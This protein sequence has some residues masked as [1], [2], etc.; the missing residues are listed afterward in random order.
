[1]IIGSIRKRVAPLAAFLLV[2]VI[3]ASSILLVASEVSGEVS[4]NIKG[5]GKGYVIVSGET[6]L[7]GT[8]EFNGSCEIV[9]ALESDVKDS[10]VMELQTKFLVNVTAPEMFPAAAPTV[11][12]G[13][14]QPMLESL[15]MTFEG[16]HETVSGNTTQ[17]MRVSGYVKLSNGK[18]IEFNATMTAKGA[19]NESIIDVNATVDIEEGTLSEE[20][21]SRLKLLTAFL[22]PEMLNTQLE[23]ANIT[24]IHINELSMNFSEIDGGGVLT[25]TSEMLVKRPP[26]N[27]TFSGVGSEALKALMD[28]SRELGKLNSSS[29]IWM[30][31]NITRT[32]G[33]EGI[34]YSE[35]NISYTVEGDLEKVAELIHDFLVKLSNPEPGSGMDELVVLPSDASLS[36]N[37]ICRD[38]KARLD[39]VFDG[40]KIKHSKLTGPEAESRIASIIVSMI[41]VLKL[42]IKPTVRVSTNIEGISNVS[43]DPVVMRSVIIT[44]HKASEKENLPEPLKKMIAQIET[45]ETTTTTTTTTTSVTTTTPTETTPTTASSTATPTTTTPTTTTTPGAGIPT[46][47]VIGIVIA[48]VVIAGVATVLLRKR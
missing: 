40:L 33:E 11:S 22:T 21:I 23:S 34:F 43:T 10:R 44:L 36:L 30:I 17:N 48:V 38:S 46:T 41:E 2:V 7:E 9:L 31:M 15:V 8:G 25:A 32:T 42:G 37:L 6:H 12:F 14:A 39:F 20:E 35:G 18:D 29:S 4:I 47:T 5:S 27:I 13:S 3:L 45:P 28:L 16:G 26:A 1:M 19:V 24:W